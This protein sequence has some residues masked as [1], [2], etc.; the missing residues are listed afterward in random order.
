MDAGGSAAGTP[1]AAGGPAVGV[2]GGPAVA[3]APAVGGNAVAVGTTV[4][5]ATPGGFASVAGE[6]PTVID[7][8]GACSSNMIH[9]FERAPWPSSSLNFRTTRAAGQTP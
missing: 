7:S 5:E 4:A 9:N 1:E 3:G 8:K 2:A 6:L